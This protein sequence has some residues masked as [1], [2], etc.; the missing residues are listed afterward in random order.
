ATEPDPVEELKEHVSE[1]GD[2]V[3][4]S[5]YTENPELVRKV[6]AA[7]L[8]ALREGRIEEPIDAG[9][10]LMLFR[11]LGLRVQV[12]TKLMVHREGETKDLRKAIEEK[13]HTG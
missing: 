11:R 13:W 8:K 9:D 6:S 2:E 3:L 5:A 7:L 1:R 4:A 12:E 10:L